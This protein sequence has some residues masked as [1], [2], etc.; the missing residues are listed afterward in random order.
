[1]L[2]RKRCQCEHDSCCRDG[3]MHCCSGPFP[4]PSPLR[5]AAPTGSKSS[6]SGRVLLWTRQ[7][8]ERRFLE[9]EQREPQGSH[10]AQDRLP[11]RLLNGVHTSEWSR[12]ARRGA[13][14]HGACS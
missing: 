4:L 13:R 10:V 5:P 1:V 8:W 7:A 2:Q 3:P 14:W 6:A 12:E 11:A 9:W